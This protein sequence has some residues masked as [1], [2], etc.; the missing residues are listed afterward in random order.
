M[1][2]R[3]LKTRVTALREI[4]VSPLYVAIAAIGVIAYYYLFRYLILSSNSGVFLLTVPIYLVYALVVTSGVL[5]ATSIHNL[6]THMQLSSA[7]V[8]EGLASAIT[9]L[10][11]GAIASCGCQFSVLASFLYLFGIGSVQA[12]SIVL[13]LNAYQLQLMVVFIIVNLLLLY[14]GLGKSSQM[15]TMKVLGKSRA[16]S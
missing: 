10:I 3:Q 5:L 16:R 1:L 13:L 15:R 14:Y 7:S 8:E 12:T 2:K 11:G 4:F 9:P 6:K